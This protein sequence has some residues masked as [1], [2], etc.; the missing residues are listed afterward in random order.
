M[1]GFVGL[2]DRF[3]GVFFRSHRFSLLPAYSTPTRCVPPSLASPHG[4]LGM[5]RA[6][7]QPARG[8]LACGWGR[9]G[10]T[11]RGP[12]GR[13][14]C[15]IVWGA[16]RDAH[17]CAHPRTPAGCI[18]RGTCW[19]RRRDLGARGAIICGQP[20]V[21]HFSNAPPPPLHSSPRAPHPTPLIPMSSNAPI[22]EIPA[23]DI[24]KKPSLKKFSEQLKKSFTP[25]TSSRASTPAG[26]S[27][28]AT[29][30]AGASSSSPR[31]VKAEAK[32][33]A[34]VAKETVQKKANQAAVATK[35]AADKAGAAARDAGA[36]AKKAINVRDRER[37]L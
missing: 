36:K 4:G 30:K 10:W 9:G 24:E 17:P 11:A 16:G 8:V 1:C 28:S 14:V 29:P 25:R 35:D 18:D 13:A 34:K 2:V 15:E 37:G 19:R 3:F 33:A 21:V 32:A 31:D 20:T 5:P 27:A 7:W 6:P 23:I 22:P 26:P 12:V